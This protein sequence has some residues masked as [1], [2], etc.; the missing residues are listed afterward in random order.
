MS[1]DH[2]YRVNRE[3][4]TRPWIYDTKPEEARKKPFESLHPKV[5]RRKENEH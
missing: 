3:T 5:V 1:E 2:F 4:P